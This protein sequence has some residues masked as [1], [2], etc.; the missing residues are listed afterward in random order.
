MIDNEIL[1]GDDMN[2]RAAFVAE[3]Y[4]FMTYRELREALK[5]AGF[6][7]SEGSL[8]RT[9]SALKRE[10]TIKAKRRRTR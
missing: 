5:E 7:S 3:R 1:E 10:G 2:E 8:R 4:P 9:L 6:N